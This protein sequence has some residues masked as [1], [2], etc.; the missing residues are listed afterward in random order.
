MRLELFFKILVLVISFVLLG[1]K[2]SSASDIVNFNSA[3]A[4]LLIPLKHQTK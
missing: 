4:L 3:L 1:C 2:Y